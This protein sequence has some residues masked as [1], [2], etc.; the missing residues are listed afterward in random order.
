MYFCFCYN[1]FV[2]FGPNCVRTSGP[3]TS[4]FPGTGG[5]GNGI[6]S[7]GYNTYIAG[8]TGSSILGKANAG[9]GAFVIG[10]KGDQIPPTPHPTAAPTFMPTAAPTRTC[11]LWTLSDYG[12]S[13]SATC[14]KLSRTCKD[15]YLKEVVSQSPSTPSTLKRA[16]CRGRGHCRELLFADH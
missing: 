15:K 7:K 13:C 4:I 2:P 14:G 12:E 6:V 16:I 5:R 3:K 8:D 1:Y 9:Y 10:L 11:M